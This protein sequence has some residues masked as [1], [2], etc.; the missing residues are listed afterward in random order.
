[1]TDP[2]RLVNALKRTTPKDYI[3]TLPRCASGFVGRESEDIPLRCKARSQGT[4]PRESPIGL[5]R[6]LLRQFRKSATIVKAIEQT[7]QTLHPIGNFE[8][9]IPRPS[10]V[11]A[12]VQN[13][14]IASV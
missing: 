6:P 14:R 13:E 5:V 10:D 7:P 1:M 9:F 3:E 12:G 4:L 11:N 8:C 2:E